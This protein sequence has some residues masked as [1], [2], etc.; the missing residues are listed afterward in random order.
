MKCEIIRPPPGSN[1]LL[2][3]ERVWLYTP[4]NKTG[5]SSKLT[6]NW[7]GPFR[8]LAKKSPVNYLLDSNEERNITQVVHVNRLKPFISLDSRPDDT[9][10]QEATTTT[11]DEPNDSDEEY[12][13]ASE[14]D[15]AEL[16]VDKI[17]DKRTTKNRSGRKETQYLI[18][19]KDKNI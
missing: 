13:T 18:Q 5:L 3:G 14:S 10:K 7:H 6:H 8:I 17:L 9:P 4:N 1:K 2:V 11:N 15:Q 16:E 19:W 12:K